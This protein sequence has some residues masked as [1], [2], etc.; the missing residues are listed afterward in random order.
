MINLNTLYEEINSRGL[1]AITHQTEQVDNFL[2]N[3]MVDHRRGLTLLCHL[4]AH[5]TRNINLC[6]EQLKKKEPAFYYYPSADMHL[7]ILDLIAAKDNFVLS[8][9]DAVKYERVL[10]EVVRNVSPIEWHF[11]GFMIS[12]SALMVKG[13][14]SPNLQALRS[15]IRQ[16]LPANGLQLDERYPTYSGHVTVARFK[17]KLER[18]QRLL[19]FIAQNQEIEVGRFQTESIDLVI[20]DWYNHHVKVLSSFRL[21]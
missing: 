15:A 6:L 21:E 12:P 13:F 4:P 9:E 20:H 5:V 19:E 17:K 1:D 14:Y 7:T 3:S 11:T 18:P 10:K 8:D 16:L 2:Q